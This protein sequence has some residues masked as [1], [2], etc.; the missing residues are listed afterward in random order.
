MT[1]FRQ[2]IAPFLIV[3]IFVMALVAVSARIF[4]PDDMA[5]PAPMEEVSACMAPNELEPSLNVF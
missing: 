3:L 5:Q 2:N 1:F 4:L